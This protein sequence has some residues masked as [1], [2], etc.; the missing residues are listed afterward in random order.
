MPIRYQ[1]N[2]RRHTSLGGQATTTIVYGRQWSASY[3]GRAWRPPTD[4]YETIDAVVVK[5]EVAGMAEDSF[6]VTFADGNLVVQGVRSDPAEK[7]G[8]HQMEIAYG[9][10]S[11]EVSLAMPILPDQIAATY[12]NGFL[13]ISLPKDSRRY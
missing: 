2:T 5:L 8:Y 1:T 11:V 10:F 7:V 13:I 9:E 6:D 4:V 12:D 3:Q